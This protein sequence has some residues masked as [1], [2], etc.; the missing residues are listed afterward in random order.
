MFPALIDKLRRR[1]DLSVGRSG[2]G[3]GGDHG[4]PRA[5]GADRRLPDR[6]GDERRAARR[7][8]RPGADDARACDEAVERASAGRVR[9]LRHRRR[10]RRTRSTSRRSPRSSSRLRRP[11]RQARQS[12]RFRAAAAAPICSRRSASTSTAPPAVVERCLDEG[13]HRVLLRAGLPSV[14]AARRRRRGRSS[15]CGRRST[16]SGR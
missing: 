15:A 7:N 10:R 2:G 5:A 6:A 1:E 12:Q 8:R 11:R 16:C 3:D 14:D 4:R 13:G 9:H